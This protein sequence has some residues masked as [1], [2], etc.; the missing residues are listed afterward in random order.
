MQENEKTTVPIPSVGADGEQS[1]SYV[2]NEIITTGNE[3]I[4]PID[5]SMEEMLRQ[6]QR[7]SDPSYLATMTMSQLY[8]TVYESR[9]PIIDGLLYPGTYLFVGAPKVGKSF[10]MAQIAYHV[11]TG[12]PL[13]K[14]SV[15]TGTVL[16]LALEDDYRRLQERLYRMPLNQDGFVIY[17]EKSPAAISVAENE[18][19][20]KEISYKLISYNH[21]SMKGNLQE[22]KNIILKLAELLEAK[23]SELSIVDKD[24]SSDLFY[25]FNNLN[26]RH[27]NIEPSIKGKFK[28][29]VA[30][31]SSEE[32]EYWYDETYQMC[33]LAFLRLEQADRKMEFNKL[34]SII[35]SKR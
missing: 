31:M 34:K 5:E 2:T 10:L 35:E 32:L 27:N 3:E 21:H 28:Q 13:W 7:M 23:R 1:L 11:S 4:N 26:L 14:Y 20:P 33:L 16:Y 9:L 6:M 19:I 18:E 8:D 17:V 22:K 29:A 25:L 30:D 12:I 15:H 24:F